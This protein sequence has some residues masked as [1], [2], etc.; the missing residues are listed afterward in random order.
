MKYDLEKSIDLISRTP[1]VLEVLLKDLPEEFIF[2]NEGGET[3]SPFDVVG[4]LLHGEKI[5]WISRLEIVLSENVER[6]F[7]PFDRF[8]EFEESK[9][10]TMNRLLEEFKTARAANIRILKEKNIQQEDFFRTAI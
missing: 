8:A 3:W 9:G 1:L 6:T 10:K 5:E 2:S 4:H 7:N